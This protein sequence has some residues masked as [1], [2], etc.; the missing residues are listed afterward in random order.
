MLFS[1]DIVTKEGTAFLHKT[2]KT[3]P[4]IYVLDGIV[5]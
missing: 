1:D 4:L 3:Y 2:F 5:N